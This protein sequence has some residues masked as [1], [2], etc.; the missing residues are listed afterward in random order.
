MHRTTIIQDQM[1]SQ[2][3]L[4]FIALGI[5]FVRFGVELPINMLG[6][7]PIIVNF[8]FGKLGR[9]TMKWTLM[10]TRN[11]SLNYLSSE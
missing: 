3:R 6:A 9:E 4:F 10:K 1:T 8:V 11:K 2:I 5:Q 7:L